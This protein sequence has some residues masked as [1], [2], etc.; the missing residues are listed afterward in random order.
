MYERFTDRARWVAI[1]AHHQAMSC[2]HPLIGTEHL[3]IA[4]TAQRGGV[5]VRTL[6]S[7]GISLPM[8]RQQ[9]AEI[10]GQGRTEL[11]ECTRFSANAKLAF[12]LSLRESLRFGDGT[13]GTGHLL[14]GLARERGGIAPQILEMFGIDIGAIRQAVHR[15]RMALG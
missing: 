14:L 8:I 15:Q 7:F 5:A 2:R 9:V 12:E 13:I 10:V 1:S 4:L 11:H 6:E 3:L